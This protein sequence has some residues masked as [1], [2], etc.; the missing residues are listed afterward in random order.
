MRA[1]LI[2]LP[3]TLVILLLS[4]GALLAAAVPVLL[5]LCAVATAVGLAALSP[6]TAGERHAEQVILL[7]GLAVGVDYS[8]FYVRR[9]REERAR[10]RRPPTPSTSPPAPPAAPSSSRA[11]PSRGDVRHVPVGPGDL[12]LLRRRDDPRRHCRRARLGDSAAGRAPLLGPRSTGRAS[13]WLAGCAARPR[14]VWPAL[15]AVVLRHP[16]GAVLFGDGPAG[17]G[18][19]TVGMRH[20]LRRT[21]TCRGRSRSCRRTTGWS[22]P[23]RGGAAHAVVVWRTTKRSTGLRHAASVSCAEKPAAA[24]RSPTWERRADVAPDGRTARSTF[25][26]P[27]TSTATGRRAR[28]RRCARL[29]ADVPARAGRRGAVTGS[30]AGSADFSDAISLACRGSSASCWR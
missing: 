21:R 27:A 30:T 28:A 8:L 15:H 7:I 6:A 14:Q 16:L 13:R 2:S 11:S 5:A 3:L 10:G 9:A 4:F 23:S 1:E 25:R 20:R 24:G 19:P 12:P 18:R 26:W 17:A 22:P 29:R